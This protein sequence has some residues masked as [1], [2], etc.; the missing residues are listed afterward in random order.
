MKIDFIF[1][2]K[3][4][5]KCVDNFQSSESVRLE[6]SKDRWK[7]ICSIAQNPGDSS[8]AK[9]LHSAQHIIHWY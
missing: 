3:C 6:Q 8:K 7:I 5:R 2:K 1:S 4:R 9:V